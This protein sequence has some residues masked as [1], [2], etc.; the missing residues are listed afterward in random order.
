MKILRRAAK[1]L[2]SIIELLISKFSFSLARLLYAPGKNQRRGDQGVALFVVYGSPVSRV[3]AGLVGKHLS[4]HGYRQ[5]IST[6]KKL[7]TSYSK[8]WLADLD[9]ASH[10]F[11]SI[12][13]L[14]RFIE[15]ELTGHYFFKR[16]K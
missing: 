13:Q 9:N 14:T 1:S 2:T 4:M 12:D 10:R 5:W 16:V 15:Q 8:E 7:L 11:S 3:I 6:P